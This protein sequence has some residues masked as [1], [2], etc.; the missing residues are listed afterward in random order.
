MIPLILGA[1]STAGAL[2]G[3]RRQEK[4]QERMSSTAA[5][6]S[7][8]DYKAAGL[9][10]ALAYDRTA[11]S[12][13][14]TNMGEAVSTGIN[15]AITAATAR[16]NIENMRQQ[17]VVMDAQAEQAATQSAKNRV[18]ANVAK[19]NERLLDQEFIFRGI[20]QPQDLRLRTAQALL[21]ELQGRS[22]ALELPGKQNTA[23]WETRLGQLGPGMNSAKTLAEIIRMMIRR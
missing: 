22:T 7:V 8:A 14:G 6:R 16:E 18:D 21:A 4:F 15:N 19:A 23:N 20:N 17:R 13:M 12:P 11:S 9:N 2:Y 10:P 5:Q 1:L 3:A